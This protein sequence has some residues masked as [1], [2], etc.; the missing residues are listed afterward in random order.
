MK[1]E[2]KKLDTL[3][4][5]ELIEEY[6]KLSDVCFDIMKEH[7]KTAEKYAEQVKETAILAMELK[8][9]KDEQQTT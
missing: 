3:T 4:K 1:T 6:N 8:K 9:F 7:H 2:P 5:E